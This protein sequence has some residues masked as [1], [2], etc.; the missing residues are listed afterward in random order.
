MDFFANDNCDKTIM[1][2]IMMHTQTLIPNKNREILMKT[3]LENGSRTNKV[4][5]IFM[6]KQ[7]IEIYK[8]IKAR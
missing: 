3:R 6:N 4:L 5:N 7:N 8:K 1:M 2:T